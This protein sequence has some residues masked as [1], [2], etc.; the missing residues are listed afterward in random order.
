MNTGITKTPKGNYIYKSVLIKV[1]EQQVS[2][3]WANR[4]IIGKG[5]K[6]C[7]KAFL[8]LKEVCF[9]IKNSK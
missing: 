8:T 6:N 5:N 3:G 9:A 1:E 7:G 2:T 4:Y